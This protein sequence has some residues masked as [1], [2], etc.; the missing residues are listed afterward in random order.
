[1]NTQVLERSAQQQPRECV[2]VS[3]VRVVTK[4]AIDPLL[5]VGEDVVQLPLEL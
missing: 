2:Q 4:D 5:L 3:H 1:M